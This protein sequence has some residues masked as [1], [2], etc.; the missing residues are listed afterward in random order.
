MAG[1][2][3][4]NLVEVAHEMKAHVKYYTLPN[5]CAA[6]EE[7]LDKCLNG[8]AA[9][10]Y[11]ERY[12]TKEGDII[13]LDAKMNFDSNA[14]YRHKDILEYRDLNEEE[15]TEIEA[16]KSSGRAEVVISNVPTAPLANRRVATQVSS[17]SISA[18]KVSMIELIS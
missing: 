13:C 4:D 16:S 14:L 15:P 10:R 11:E 9:L 7:A 17:T 1:E 18:P 8:T 5:D 3:G 2:P 12:C 6:Y